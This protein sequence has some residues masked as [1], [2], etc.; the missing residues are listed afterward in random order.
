MVWSNSLHFAVVR[1]F[2]GHIVLDFSFTSVTLALD[3][4]CIA[5]RMDT[6]MTHIIISSLGQ[7]VGHSW[8]SVGR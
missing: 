7:Y 2:H 6:L 1:C 5:W 3:K 8:E 4:H